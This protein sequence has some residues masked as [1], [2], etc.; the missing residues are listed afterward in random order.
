[1]A[2]MTQATVTGITA[3]RH[4]SREEKRELL[5][6]MQRATTDRNDVIESDE[7]EGHQGTNSKQGLK[8]KYQNPP[9]LP[10]L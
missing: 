3:M 5:K 4:C 2:S 1:M 7:E 8:D 6:G 9:S 10:Q